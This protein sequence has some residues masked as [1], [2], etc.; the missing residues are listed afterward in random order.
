MPLSRPSHDDTRR[1]AIFGDHAVAL[2]RAGLAVLPAKGKRPVCR[3]FN[4]MRRAPCL[5]VV[6]KWAKTNA[7][8]DIVY[9]PGLSR[10]H[11]NPYG[12]VVVDIDNSAEVERAV[13]VFGPTPA[14]I[15]TRRGRHLVYGAPESPLGNVGSLR[16]SGFNIDIKH[17][18]KG[19]GISVA[20]PSR[21][22]D[23][24][25]FAYAWHN[26]SGPDTLADLPP[27]NLKALQDL[28]ARGSETLSHATGRGSEMLH[29]VT[30]TAPRPAGGAR[31]ESKLHSDSRGLGLNKFLAYQG[32]Y[33]DTSISRS[34][35]ASRRPK[36]AS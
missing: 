1:T 17:G 31:C 15:D 2:R 12:V 7:E 24:R 33:C 30:G 21:H 20:P 3:H 34:R 19:S 5:A 36:Q 14:M 10:T 16:K 18:Q 27:F 26:G 25:D 11:R 13:E 22:A 35:T 8:C 9:V 6:E 4:T 32:G 23:Q 29:N 28:L